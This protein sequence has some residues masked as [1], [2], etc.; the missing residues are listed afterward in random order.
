MRVFERAGS[1]DFDL[2]LD[3]VDLGGRE[4]GRVGL[5]LFIFVRFY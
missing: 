4:D 5:Y 1:K 2:A 3:R